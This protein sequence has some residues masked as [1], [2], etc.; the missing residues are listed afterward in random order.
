MLIAGCDE[1]SDERTNLKCGLRRGLSLRAHRECG[2]RG[3]DGQRETRAKNGRV[4]RGR[5]AHGMVLEVLRDIW[6]ISLDA[7]RR[8]RDPA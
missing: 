2:E 7:K 3:G 6:C 1:C 4:K 5:S 8:K